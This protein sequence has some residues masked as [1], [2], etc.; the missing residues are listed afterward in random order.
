[1]LPKVVSS[2]PVPLLGPGTHVGPAVCELPLQKQLLTHPQAQPL[3]K[4]LS[5]TKIQIS[6]GQGFTNSSQVTAV[7]SQMQSENNLHDLP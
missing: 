3:H 2:W 5:F 7:K 4:H 6:N 1:M